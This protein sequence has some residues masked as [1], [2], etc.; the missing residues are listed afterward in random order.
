MAST[1]SLT[2]LKSRG[3]LTFGSLLFVALL[4]LAGWNDVLAED[5]LFVNDS[6]TYCPYTLCDGGKNGFVVD[7]VDAIYKSAGYN[8]KI[9]N[10]PWNRAILMVRTGHANGILGILKGSAPNF[11]YPKTEVA[12]YTPAVF[13]LK[14]NPWEFTGVDSLKEVHLGLVQNYDNG[15][16]D[17]ALE[18]YLASDPS[19]V[20]YIS[21][22]Q[23][24]QHLFMMIEANHTDATIDDSFV[25]TYLLQKMGKQKLFKLTPYPVKPVPAYIG[26]NNKDQKSQRLADVFDTGLAKLR[27]T[28]ELKSILANY[29]LTDWKK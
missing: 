11:I 7:I 9:V 22:E 21:N 28:G 29:G 24:L 10:V 18:R 19:N 16:F 5:I 8:V 6:A 1:I 20:A 27:K 4:A 17:P 14:A 2:P 3:P 13:S 25:G 26:F 12:S 15:S 23:P